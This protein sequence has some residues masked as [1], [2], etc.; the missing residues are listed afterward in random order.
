[1]A[2]GVW[3]DVLGDASKSCIFTDHALDAARRESS[4]VTRGVGCSCVPAVIQK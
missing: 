2:H 4:V 3:A 1:M